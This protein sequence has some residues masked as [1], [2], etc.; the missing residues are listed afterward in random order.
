MT[1]GKNRIFYKY[2]LS[3]IIVLIIPIVLLGVSSYKQ[4][5]NNLYDQVSMNHMDALEQM[6]ESIDGKLVEMNKIA[7]QM[8]MNSDLTPYALH[9]D[10]Y[11]VYKAK[12]LLDYK[13]AND[14]FHEILLYI[15]DYDFLYSARST[16]SLSSFIRE[17]YPF[18]GWSE[19]QFKADMNES[20]KP[21]VRPVDGFTTYGY[22]ERYLTYMVPVPVN[23]SKPYGTAMFLIGDE[24]LHY[25]MNEKMME[26]SDHGNTLIFD[27][28]NRLLTSLKETS[29]SKDSHFYEL[30]TSSEEATRTIKLDNEKYMV[31]YDKSE[32]T[33]WTYM[34][35]LPVDEALSPVNKVKNSWF[36]SLIL[37][38]VLGGLTIYF[39]MIVNYNPI[40]KLA[41]FA[42][43]TWGK[44]SKERNEI[45][46]VRKV[47]NQLSES[48]SQLDHQLSESKYAVKEHLLHR[49]LTGEF[50]DMNSFNELGKDSDVV[51][52][53]PYYAVLIMQFSAATTELKQRLLTEVME[54][55]PEDIEGYGKDTVESDKIILIL[56]IDSEPSQLDHWIEGLRE[57]FS[58]QYAVPLTVGIGR[59]V[60]QANQLGISYIEAS[61]AIDYKLIR[62][63][64]TTIYFHDVVADTPAGHMYP[65]EDIELLGRLIKQGNTDKITEL[66]NKI[67]RGLEQN[68][69][70]L[71]MAR[72]VCFDMIT[73][74]HKAV[75]QLNQGKSLLPQEYPDVLS[76]MQFD[77][78]GEL[79]DLIS[80][81]C[82]DLCQEI[83]GPSNVGNDPLIDEM[84]LYIR[85]HY[86]D[87][88]FSIQQMA[89]HFAIS[90]SYLSRYFKE[91]TD[92][93]VS[94]YL[95]EI[96][97]EQA[98][99]LLREHD[100][101]LKDIVHMIG[102]SDSSSF[103]RKFKKQEGMTPG[104]YRKLYG[105]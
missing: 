100:H 10:F 28:N 97:I 45:E 29:Y 43:L 83:Q 14:Y 56:G 7:A 60:N 98:K 15:R 37:I 1:R 91:R 51:F 96:R 68:S 101:S 4:T 23:S 63:N 50:E 11:Q 86:K 9:Q 103:I 80:K 72:C 66:I 48:H 62:G 65:R 38:V 53:K 49:L 102:Y 30:V 59:C 64:N 3:Y 70:T 75:E 61:M 74:V 34:M 41:K 8:G 94:D 71:F 55:L 5:V 25:L 24:S 44:S 36:K 13:S 2:L 20:L 35:L 69:T 58:D 105:D 27:Q 104:E 21:V 16:Y 99:K 12:S 32:Q 82:Y 92:R 47:I 17:I 88:N 26:R 95:N 22:D 90:L 54:Q 79:A 42:E 33:G 19:A 85:E 84:K 6:K 40:K 57:Y 77:T 67:V 31:S 76:I 39:G 18:Q 87:Y 81:L 73:T 46:T 93:N 89:D 78:V 52:T